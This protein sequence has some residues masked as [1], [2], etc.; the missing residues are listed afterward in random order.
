M[1]K[2]SFEKLHLTDRILQCGRI[3]KLWVHH[4]HLKRFFF[5]VFP[6]VSV[7]TKGETTY[8]SYMCMHECTLSLISS[9]SDGEYQTKNVTAIYNCKETEAQNI[10]SL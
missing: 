6:Y 2:N 10:L 5:P 8:T 4:L 9:S 3:F 7:F 1:Y